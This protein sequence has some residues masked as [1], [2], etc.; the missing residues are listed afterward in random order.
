[1]GNQYVKVS[2]DG[3]AVVLQPPFSNVVGL[4][5]LESIQDCRYDFVFG[6]EVSLLKVFEELIG[7]ELISGKV[8]EDDQQF[9]FLNFGSYGR[10]SKILISLVLTY[11][12]YLFTFSQIVQISCYQIFEE[13]I[14]DLLN[15]EE[16]DTRQS[17]N[18]IGQS[19]SRALSRLKICDRFNGKAV[20]V[21][22]VQKRSFNRNQQ[23]IIEE[24]LKKCYEYANTRRKISY[25]AI[26]YDIEVEGYLFRIVQLPQVSSSKFEKEEQFS[27]GKIAAMQAMATLRRFLECR[28]KRQT[29]DL[30][31]QQYMV[32]SFRQSKMTHLLKDILQGNGSFAFLGHVGGSACQLEQTIEILKWMQ[33]F[34]NMDANMIQKQQSMSKLLTLGLISPGKHM[35]KTTASKNIFSS[36]RKP[37]TVKEEEV[38]IQGFG[39][40]TQ[41]DIQTQYIG[42]SSAR[43]LQVENRGMERSLFSKQDRDNSKEYVVFLESQLE[44]AD[45]ELE[46]AHE[47]LQKVRKAYTTKCV[48]IENLIVENSILR[49]TLESRQENSTTIIDDGSECET[50]SSI[51]L[52]SIQEHSTTFNDIELIDEEH[53]EVDS[54][55]NQIN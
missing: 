20:R 42:N 14:F 7:K 17:F 25:G 30:V 10:D 28:Q 33:V 39:T 38:Y 24:I 31:Q 27:R 18:T 32:G 5:D 53:D 21:M 54:V 4:K 16:Y 47:E 43:S 40:E 26:F 46:I 12:G 19:P 52:E 9:T 22:G 2:Q 6:P 15:H 8:V 36:A 51:S 1:M 13:Q 34:R 37:M 45:K 55:R 11:I 29:M 23:Q 50:K 35:L 49:Q 48:E 3:K 41:Q 44:I